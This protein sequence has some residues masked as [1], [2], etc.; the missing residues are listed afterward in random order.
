M[1]RK[2]RRD[3]EISH[4]SSHPS[5]LCTSAMEANKC[6]MEPEIIY[7]MKRRKTHAYP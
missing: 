2:R 4:A 3:D 7:S 6:R 1:T 5:F